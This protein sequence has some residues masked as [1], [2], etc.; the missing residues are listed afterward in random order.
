MM[1]QKK[2]RYGICIFQ[3]FQ[4]DMEKTFNFVVDCGKLH[5]CQEELD[6]GVKNRSAD[7]VRRERREM[8]EKMNKN[9]FSPSSQI[10]LSN[11]V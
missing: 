11:Q 1:I 3:L 10:P 7:E 9:Y 6:S 2:T 4:Q 8:I 5:G